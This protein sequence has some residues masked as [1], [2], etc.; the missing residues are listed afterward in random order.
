MDKRSKMYKAVKKAGHAAELNH[1]DASQLSRWAAGILAKEGRKIT[2]RT[3]DLFLSKTG[4]DMDNIRME[5]EKLISYTMGRDVITD[6]DVE[7][8]CTTQ[9]A[10]QIFDMISA[11]AARQT[12]RAMDLYEDLLALK[13]PPM[14]I[15]FLIAR[16]FNQI[17]QVKEQSAKEMNKG[18]IAG[19]M[20]IQPFVVGKVLPQ[21]RAF[22]REQITF[23][24]GAVCP[25]GGRGKDG[26]LSDRL[27]VE[28]L[29]TKEYGK[30]L[31]I[32][33]PFLVRA[34]RGSYLERY[35]LCK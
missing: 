15:L 17:L 22:S 30:K 25:D 6:R 20:K 7:E 4:D 11:L 14:R 18:T 13:E 12:R 35:L 29:L 19:K 27:A 24:C 28:L 2:G 1:Q 5:L 16:Q 21:A 9:A 3:M 34:N 23:L 31:D 26:R 33:R 32:K 8:I 10:N